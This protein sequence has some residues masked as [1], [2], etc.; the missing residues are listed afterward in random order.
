MEPLQNSRPFTHRHRAPAALRASSHLTSM[1]DVSM[2]RQW[3]PCGYPTGE[4]RNCCVHDGGR[5]DHGIGD[6]SLYQRV[7]D[8][9]R[10][11]VSLL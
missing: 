6:Q 10:G 8:H 3:D 11:K 4:G 2:R 1:I 5:S 9:R 7:G